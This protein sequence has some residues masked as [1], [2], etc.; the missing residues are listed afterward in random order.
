MGGQCGRKAPARKTHPT[1][2]AT[3]RVVGRTPGRQN[4]SPVSDLVLSRAAVRELD[5]RASEEFG[6]PSILLMENAGRACADAAERLAARGPQPIVVLCGPGNNGGDGLVLARTLHNRGRAVRV[7]F[8]GPERMLAAGSVDFRLNLML[9]R[10]LGRSVSLVENEAGARQLAE[11]LGTVPL[12]VDALFG[13]GLVRELEEPWRSA[14]RALNASG[15]PVLAVDLPSGL[16]AD[17]GAVHGAA[18]RATLTV[19][20]VAQKLGMLAGRGPELCGRVVVAEIGIPRPLLEEAA[21]G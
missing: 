16:D 10:G 18:V 6:V 3:T 20:F 9:W 14:I 8:V 11:E 5:R 21:R 15:R 1:D 13:T 17:T 2:A 4:L 7:V 19:T 12:A